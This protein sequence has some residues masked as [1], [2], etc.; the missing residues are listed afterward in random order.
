MLM[1]T[2]SL[3]L[4]LI[5]AYR[6]NLVIDVGSRDGI[7]AL[8]FSDMLPEAEVVAF[9]A[10]PFNFAAMTKCAAFRE[11]RIAVLPLAITNTDGATVFHITDADYEASD[12]ADNNR[13][14]SSTLAHEGARI[15]YSVFPLGY[16]HQ[17]SLSSM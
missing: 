12:T 10:N 17:R 1:N 7:Q 15:R 13:G 11:Q 3:F 9:E 2:K 8:A 16:V 14:T 4:S 5:R 6:C